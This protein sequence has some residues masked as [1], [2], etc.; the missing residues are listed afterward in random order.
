MNEKLTKYIN[1]ADMIAARELF[2][3]AT[4]KHVLYQLYLNA[5]KCHKK[6]LAKTDYDSVKAC[7]CY[8]NFI[9][10]ATNL[11][12]KEFCNSAYNPFS[13]K[14]RIAAAALCVEA[15]EIEVEG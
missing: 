4:N 14:T 11:Y 9:K 3:Y 10:A 5:E 8:T 1:G 13:L 15:V 12:N 7:A 6:H 2:L